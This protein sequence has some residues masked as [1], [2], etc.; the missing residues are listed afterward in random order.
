MSE[1]IHGRPHDPR[2]ADDHAGFD[3]VPRQHA[4]EVFERFTREFSDAAMVVLILVLAG[5]VVAGAYW[6]GR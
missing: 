1:L 2:M 4:D 3:Q 6:I 5:V